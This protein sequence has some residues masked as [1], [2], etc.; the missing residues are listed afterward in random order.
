MPDVERIHLSP[1]DMTDLEREALLRAFDS[2]WITTMGAE[3]DAFEAEGFIWGGRWY[4][5]DS[6]H[7]EYRPE[8]IA[9]AKR[10][11]PRE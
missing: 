8:L 4:H 11:W 7:F 6:L 9:L 2:N 5:F 10:G 3:V 1:P